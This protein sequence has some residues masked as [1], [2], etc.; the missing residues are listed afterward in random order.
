MKWASNFSAGAGEFLTA[1]IT[2]WINRKTGAASV[3]NTNS[4]AYKAGWW[5]GAGLTVATTAA[6][7]VTAQAVNGVKEGIIYGRG[8]NAL[9][10][11]G[12]VRFGWYWTGT[13][14]AV[15]LRIGEAA[16]AGRAGTWIHWHIP[17]WHP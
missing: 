14:D 5:T 16:R 12:K 11:S 10:N 8:A 6:G 3:I 9:L 13:R 4:G 2:S 1:G 15:G 7:S 17:F